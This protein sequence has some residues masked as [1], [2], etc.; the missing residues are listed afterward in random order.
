VWFETHDLQR[1]AAAALATAYNPDLITWMRQHFQEC[2]HK[3]HGIGT[4]CAQ[5]FV[6]GTQRLQGGPFTVDDLAA[7]SLVSSSG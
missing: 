4:P 5:P 2:G 1:D 7:A 3:F 6:A